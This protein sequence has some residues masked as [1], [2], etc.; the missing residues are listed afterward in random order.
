MYVHVNASYSYLP[1]SPFIP[2]SPVRPGVPFDPG[3]PFIPF[4][5]PGPVRPGGPFL[6]GGP[7]SP[8]SPFRPGTPGSPESPRQQY[9]HISIFANLNLSFVT[10]QEESNTDSSIAA[11]LQ[12]RGGNQQT[13][14]S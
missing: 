6:P 3:A 8:G 2:F 1:F 4:S 7:G 10:S 9:K 12:L 5:P 13:Y 11:V 14:S